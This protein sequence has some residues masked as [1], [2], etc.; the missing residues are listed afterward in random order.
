MGDEFD[1]Y[2]VRSS[3]DVLDMPVYAGDIDECPVSEDQVPNGAPHGEAADVS[4]YSDS[5]PEWKLQ[6]ITGDS[7]GLFGLIFDYAHMLPLEASADAEFLPPGDR[8]LTYLIVGD[9]L[10]EG[11][12]LGLAAERYQ[13]A[14]D[15][16]GSSCYADGLCERLFEIGIATE[17]WQ[18]A[19][20]ASDCMIEADPDSVVDR[21]VVKL[22]KVHYMLGEYG[23]AMTYFEAGR[24]LYHSKDE[25][26]P[27]AL[28]EIE[29]WSALTYLTSCNIREAE[30]AVE[31]AAYQTFLT[32]RN[33]PEAAEAAEA[34]EEV[35]SV[36]HRYRAW[37]DCGKA[38]HIRNVWRS[39]ER[40]SV[41]QFIAIM[42]QKP[43]PLDAGFL[44]QML[45]DTIDHHYSE[46][47]KAR[48]K[49]DKDK[50]YTNF[51]ALAVLLS[52]ATS[53]AS[54]LRS[55]GLK[56]GG[57]SKEPLID[58]ISKFT[59]I[60]GERL[61]AIFKE[62]SQYFVD[63]LTVE[64]LTAEKEREA[65]RYCSLV[66]KTQS[67]IAPDSADVVL[68]T[69]KTLMESSEETETR[70]LAVDILEGYID[71]YGYPE[72]ELRKDFVIERGYAWR[73]YMEALIHDETVDDDLLRVV[74]GKAKGF[75]EEAANEYQDDPEVWLNLAWFFYTWGKRE[76]ND[77]SE[78]I[79]FAKAVI[80]KF[81]NRPTMSVST[82]V[83][84]QVSTKFLASSPSPTASQMAEAERIWGWSKLR[85]ADIEIAYSKFDAATKE[86]VDSVVSLGEG[87]QD[88]AVNR[89]E[90]RDAVYLAAYASYLGCKAENKNLFSTHAP[91]SGDFDQRLSLPEQRVAAQD[92]C[93]KA[94][95]FVLDRIYRKDQEHMSAEVFYSLGLIQAEEFNF[96]KLSRFY[97]NPLFHT[98][99]VEGSYY[100]ELMGFISMLEPTAA[101]GPLA[102]DPLEVIEEE[103]GRY[104]NVDQKVK[105]MEAEQIG[106]FGAVEDLL[107]AFKKDALEK[108]KLR[109]ARE[110]L[111][112]ALSYGICMSEMGGVSIR[113]RE[114]NLL[115]IVKLEID[116]IKQFPRAD[117]VESL[118]QHLEKA[119]EWHMHGSR[120]NIIAVL[121]G[122]A[123]KLK[124]ERLSAVLE[125]L[126][127]GLPS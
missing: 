109:I 41:A 69:Y 81:H 56:T 38:G 78:A 113:E 64:K 82:L 47:E 68:N 72:G 98:G 121:V 63:L 127:P 55:Q 5:T 90:T 25:G 30:N 110:T 116:N 22:A 43:A 27:A 1:A 49:K 89:K 101:P 11:G 124:L 61:M 32:S 42:D 28:S 106:D 118:R 102:D 105:R 31:A 95:R 33:M 71:K 88:D 79:S 14:L 17:N 45:K 77:F 75:L 111:I 91:S 50:V 120:P 83:S 39:F 125:K 6:G 51:M 70:K 87:L 119:F 92:K 122:D 9:I 65:F 60:D 103:G 97:K 112:R 12:M 115:F 10:Y 114:N 117:Y 18:L 107:M 62:T 26:D 40:L 94:K 126:K 96:G 99:I 74:Y 21:N 19:E 13:K 16:D 54:E 3:P 35:A 44:S 67:T 66:L 57:E 15:I 108:R 4:A 36:L 58:D 29:L 23:E 123:E 85:Q 7:G 76:G 73:E 104:E 93:E 52:F 24:S 34:T 86:H 53:Y 8:S 100:A 59:G 80:D 46:V 20:D 37:K 84:P 48:K 2:V